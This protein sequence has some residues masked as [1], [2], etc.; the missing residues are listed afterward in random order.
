VIF[1]A[2][3]NLRLLLTPGHELEDAIQNLLLDVLTSVNKRLG[4]DR[5]YK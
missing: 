4:D 2:T 1:F 3:T 5:E